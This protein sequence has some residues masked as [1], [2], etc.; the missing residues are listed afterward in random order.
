M[1]YRIDTPGD[2]TVER[3]GVRLRLS[4]DPGFGGKCSAAFSKAQFAFSQEVAKTMDKYVPF[5][6][7]VLKNSV[8][9]ASDFEHGELVYNTP[10]ARAQYYRRESGTDL[11][12][13]VRGSYWGQR[14]IADNKSHFEQFARAAFGGAM[15]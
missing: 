11:R 12:D 4:F 9:T 10:Y 3:N 1:S 14:C 15:K 5:R 8:L 13:G 6:S 7:G 2:V